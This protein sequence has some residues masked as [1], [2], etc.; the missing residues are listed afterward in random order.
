MK[1]L[2]VLAMAV[3]LSAVACGDDDPSGPAITP[4]TL[5]AASPSQGTVGTE[6]RI[7]GTGF[8]AGASV[9][10]NQLPSSSVDLENGALFALAPS[11]ITEGTSYDLIVANPDGG[12]DTLL[13]AFT[14]VGPEASRVNGVSK[15]TGL[16]GMTIIIEGSGFGDAVAL[17]GGKVWFTTTTGTDIE[18]VVTDSANDW[19]DGFIVTSVPTGVTDT[20]FLWVQTVTGVS[21]SIE[22]RLIQSGTFS[23]STINWSQTTAL[24]QGLQ[25]LGAVFVPV[26]EGSTP[27]NY[28]FAVGGA[29]T[30]LA[31]TDVVYRATVQA[32]GG[33]GGVWTPLAGLPAPRAYHATAAATGY[34]AALD[35]TTTA[36][37]IYVI[38]G[39]DA[40]SAVVATVFVGHV[41]LAGDVTGWSATQ[42]LPQPL[43]SAGA[44][45]FRGFL[46]VAGGTGT[47]SAAVA[48]VYRAPVAADGSLGAWE[49]LAAA[50]PVAT[51]HHSFLNFGPFL[52]VVGGDSATAAAPELA[53]NTGGEL[54]NVYRTRVNLRTGGLSEAWDSTTWMGK[55]R[56]KHSTVFAGGDLFATSGVY[57]GQAGSS[58]NIYGSVAS[59]GSVDAWNGATGSNTIGS[60]LGYHLYNQAAVA[61]IDAA[62]EGHVM[63]IGGA[64]RGAAG[65]PSAAVVYY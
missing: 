59:D 65:Q 10:F 29:D 20:S 52:Y 42:P 28:V 13:A 46:Y 25:G 19:T 53:T 63:V 7:D 47:D 50:L 4:P 41:N 35:T 55:G 30:L 61:F 45:L 60:L 21:D 26:E 2:M 43:H 8:V 62:G 22:F 38:G 39:V 40:D 24:P 9:W 33:L 37:Y 5:T 64:K 48:K 54:A 1:R 11:G 49:D 32:S 31:A 44:V 51:S 57:S 18:A 23:P 12:A 15:P 58:E 34:T 16:Q 3:A 6:V 36:A 14:A 56:S 17:S 27:A